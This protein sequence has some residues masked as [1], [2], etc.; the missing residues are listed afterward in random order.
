MRHKKIILSL[1]ISVLLTYIFVL[2]VPVG[3][4]EMASQSELKKLTTAHSKELR[5]LNMRLQNVST[6]KKYL[7]SRVTFQNKEIADCKGQ[8]SKLNNEL[9]ILKKNTMGTEK[10]VVSKAARK[11]NDNRGITKSTDDNNDSGENKLPYP[12]KG[13]Y[14]YT[15]RSIGQLSAPIRSGPAITASVLIEVPPRSVIYVL[16]KDSK[17][18][19]GDGPSYGY[20][21]VYFNG[22]K[23]YISRTFL[24]ISTV[25]RF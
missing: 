10:T 12:A 8:L 7:D 2:Y 14:Y 23:G 11:I 3:R 15:V 19:F 4:S 22:T 21:N 5:G 20:C 1:I 9:R 13:Y 25:N 17:Y 24:D 16:N 6:S 18:L